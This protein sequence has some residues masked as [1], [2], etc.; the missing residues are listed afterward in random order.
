M[1]PDAQ[2]VGPAGNGLVRLMLI[3]A[4]NVVREG[5]LLLLDEQ[6]GLSVVAQ[7]ADVDVA[8]RTPEVVDVI[9]TELDSPAHTGVGIIRALRVSFPGAAVL[10]LTQRAH[11]S[12]VDA[13]LTAGAA[14]YVVKTATPAELV[15]GIRTLARGQS[16]LQPSLGVELA[17]WHQQ[18]TTAPGLSPKEEQLLRLLA[19]G[20]TNAEIAHLSGVSLR[21]VEMHRGRVQAKTG[22]RTRAELFRF[23]RD[24]GLLRF[25][26]G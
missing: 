19:V 4:C 2:T 20:H 25:D 11:P 6:P 3:D 13:A 22:M 17:R 10:V 7:A 5:L 16:Y 12:E 14:G 24:T 9:V 8:T 21:T 23:A 18:R 1:T 15:A 26:L